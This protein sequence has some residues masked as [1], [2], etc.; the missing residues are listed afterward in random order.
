MSSDLLIRCSHARSL[1]PDE[2]CAGR[3]QLKFERIPATFRQPSYNTFVDSQLLLHE[4]ISEM[5][6]SAS[7][8]KSMAAKLHLNHPQKKR[9]CQ[10]NSN[11]TA[12]S[13]GFTPFTTTMQEL[14][15]SVPRRTRA[16][17]IAQ[18]LALAIVLNQ[19]SGHSS[20]S[21]PERS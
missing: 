3:K 9:S 2:D 5:M 19:S 1:R 17:E 16:V 8:C 13:L 12:S 14:G 10:G 11:F 4:M 21:G 20:I 6:I 7:M 18:Q 15:G